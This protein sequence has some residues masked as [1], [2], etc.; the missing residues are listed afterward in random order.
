MFQYRTES[1]TKKYAFFNQYRTES[2]VEKYDF[3]KLI[4]L[5]ILLGIFGILLLR[6]SLLLRR[7]TTITRP[8][9]YTTLTA[10]ERFTVAGQGQAGRTVAILVDAQPRGT[11]LVGQNGAWSF[12]TRLYNVG[13][14]TLQAQLTTNQNN[15]LAN[16][17]AVPLAVAPPATTARPITRVGVPT[18]DLPQQWWTTRRF[19]IRGTAE[20]G[21]TVDVFVDDNIMYT[22]TAD[23]DG[24]WSAPTQ[25]DNAGIYQIQARASNSDGIQ[26][27]LTTP[28]DLNIRTPIARL[29][30]G[31][32]VYNTI[33][34]ANGNV[35]GTLNLSGHGEPGATVNLFLMA[36]KSV[37]L[38]LTMMVIGRL[39]QS[40]HTPQAHTA[41][42]PTW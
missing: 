7:Q 28:L 3:F 11:V 40:T 24:R 35:D 39:S 27:N 29:T 16:A 10:G 17:E 34:D 8:H 31:A 22:T 20:A 9:N 41:Y 4:I 42:L 6:A 33:Q 15:S 2:E 18:L 30:L 37:K 25:F 19:Y 38:P 36:C 12:D 14:H 26:S 21:E 23:G 32:T 5:L 13:N 1:E